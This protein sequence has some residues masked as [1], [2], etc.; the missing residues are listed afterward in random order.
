MSASAPAYYKRYRLDVAQGVDRSYVD[1][2]VVRAH[3]HRLLAAGMTRRGIAI[4]A[5]VS[6]T[7]VGR[8]LD[9]HYAA[10]QRAA[11]TRLLAVTPERLLTRPDPDGFVPAVGARRRIA[12]LLALGWRHADIEQH[13]PTRHRSSVVLNQA[14]QWITRQTHDAVTTAYDAL[15]MRPGPSAATRAR[16]ARRGYAPPLAWDDDTIDDPAA[17]PALEHPDDGDID[18]VAVERA[19]AGDLGPDR[20]L[21]PAER[22][23]AVATLARRGHTDTDIAARLHITDRT[24]LRDRQ[25]NHIPSTWRAAS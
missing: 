1:V 10:C 19:I 24:V 15:S 18:Q 6:P 5:G 7:T 12:A 9:G 20:P 13:M 22:A 3:L 8:V 2:T 4:A 17:R 21:T 25:S 16:A 11:A 23:L 14:G